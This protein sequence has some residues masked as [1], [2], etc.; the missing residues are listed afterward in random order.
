MISNHPRWRLI[1]SFEFIGIVDLAKLTSIIQKHMHPRLFE[2]RPLEDEEK[3]DYL[4]DD[5]STHRLTSFFTNPNQ[6]YLGALLKGP[7]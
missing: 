3:L 1:P 7:H 5:K 6:S 2:C 4:Y